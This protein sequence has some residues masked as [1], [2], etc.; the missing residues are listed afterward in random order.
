MAAVLAVKDDPGKPRSVFADRQTARRTAKR[1]QKAM[2]AQNVRNYDKA[3]DE[4][5]ADHSEPLPVQQYAKAGKAKEYGGCN[6]HLR[7]HPLP[8]NRAKPVSTAYSRSIF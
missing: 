4:H 1:S 5:D 2:N 8:V 3:C 6:D 7:R